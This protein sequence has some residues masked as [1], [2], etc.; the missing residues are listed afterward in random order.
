VAR[1]ACN[2]EDSRPPRHPR[3]RIR[4][5]S[6]RR[7]VTRIHDADTEVKTGIVDGI[8][9]ITGQTEDLLDPFLP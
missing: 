2:H 8:D 7:F 4:H 5:E 3:P 6:R 1:T 9:V